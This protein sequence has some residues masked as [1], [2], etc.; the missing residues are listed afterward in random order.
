MHRDVAGNPPEGLEVDHI[1][2]D[3]LNLQRNNLRFVPHSTNV[4]GG[5]KGTNTGLHGVTIRHHKR[6]TRDG[7]IKIYKYI[8]A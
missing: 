5:K 8:N 3:K 6:R 1:D 4:H 7:T 2:R